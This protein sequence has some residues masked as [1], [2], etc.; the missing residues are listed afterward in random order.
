MQLN[1]TASSSPLKVAVESLAIG[2]VATQVL[3]WVSVALYERQPGRERREENRA[4]GKFQAYERAVAKVNE[5][6]GLGL[7]REEIAVWGWR[8]H[9]S[10]GIGT[11]MLYVA[12]RRK[13]PRLGLGLGLG[14]GAAF[15]L[16]LDELA[17][18]LSKLTPGPRAFSWKVHARGAAAHVAFGVAAETAVR[19]AERIERAN[20]SAR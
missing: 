17:M 15:F 6:F 9:K 14:F 4:R 20:K 12:L 5:K 13:N 7:S 3:D 8:F 2:W 11:G 16:L 1:R 10:L 19:V 18:P